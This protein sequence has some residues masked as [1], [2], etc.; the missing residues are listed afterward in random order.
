MGRG[1]S[2]GPRRVAAT[3]CVVALA[4]FGLG[5][6]TVPAGGVPT[7]TVDFAYTGAPAD[8]QVPAG[9]CQVS[10]VAVGA[11]G[12]AGAG[13]ASGLARSDGVGADV[14]LANLGAEVTGTISV[15]PGETLTVDVGG[16]GGDATASAST[17]IDSNNDGISSASATAGAGGYN[18]G[19]AGGAVE[20]HDALGN[21]SGGGVIAVA[22]ASAG[23]GGGG[24]SDVR[25][26]GTTLADRVIVAGGGGG[27]GGKGASA[28]A[29]LS[30]FSSDSNVVA[31]GGGGN[32]NGG[33]G[34]A[35]GGTSA[36]AGGTGGGGN[37]G[38]GTVGLTS[39]GLVE[40]GP[41]TV[42][43]M[44]AAASAG[45]GGG[46]GLVG[47][48]GGGAATVTDGALTGGAGGGGAG[49]ALVPAGGSVADAFNNGD[50]AVSIT[51][52]AP[53]V[54]C[55]STLQVAKVVS[56]TST[57]PYTEHVACTAPVT[58]TSVTETVVQVDLPFLADGTPNAAAGPSGWVVDT[59]R[60]ALASTDLAGATCTVTETDTGG[61]ASVTYACAWAAGVSDHVAD[62]GCPGA[63]S[64]PSSAPATVL[65]EGS[66]DRATVTVT[67]TF[68][69]GSEIAPAGAVAAQPTFTG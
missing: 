31:G 51:P 5:I 33:N 22:V 61:A 21:S 9:V 34:S 30:S 6:A 66:G 52:A 56:G 48:A 29:S 68:V 49:T 16:R 18:G 10:I 17:G 36:G 59:G 1:I 47:G 69:A 46:G 32:A 45:G 23:G 55:P 14:A 53:G 19:A 63:A 58:V 39:D 25:R 15:T 7:A 8:Y 35:G 28:A 64:G 60:W 12:G 50:G 42:N 24:A 37:T 67:N 11:S 41:E 2:R 43:L 38:A 20:H 44:F 27:A 54:G 57:H 65:F 62:V 13:N 3:A 40:S 4:A 26:G